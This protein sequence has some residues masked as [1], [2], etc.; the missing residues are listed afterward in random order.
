MGFFSEYKQVNRLLKEKMQVVFYSESRH[1]YQYFERLIKDLLANN[2]KITYITSDANDPLLNDAPKD[3]QVFYIKWMLG[4]LFK[5]IK[6][7]V[8]V[9][10]M[11]DLG[12]FLFKRSPSVGTYIYMFHAAVSTHQQYRKEAFNNY[13]AIFCTGEYQVNEIRKAEEQQ[14]IPLKQ[15]VLI[16]YGYPLIGA[17]NNEATNNNNK[18]KPTI[19]VAPSWFEGCIFD[20]CIE[21]LLDQLSKLPYNVVLRSHPEY[22]KRK[23][24][25]FRRIKKMLEKHSSMRIDTEPDVIKSLP[26]AD[27]L[28]TDR[29]GI[30]FE[31]AFGTGRP[32]LFIDTVLKET[33]PA[34][35]ELNIEPVENRLRGQLG[36]TVLPEKLNEL[37]GKIKQLG[38]FQYGFADKVKQLAK[39]IFFNSEASYQEGLDFILGKSTK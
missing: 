15:K 20:T 36:I 30:A 24:K 38:L 18:D 25:S 29:S 31:F 39:E 32:V 8:M 9:M 1:Y 37:P 11:P 14:G 23:E 35:K 4:L 27:I 17:L 21:E 16:G 26:Q 10:T 2:V 5:K 12:N 28:I 3:L 7:D 33:N 6:A 13:D 22:E 34:W 19:L